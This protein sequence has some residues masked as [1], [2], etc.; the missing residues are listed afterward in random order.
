MTFF[1]HERWKLFFQSSQSSLILLQFSSWLEEWL[2][3]QRKSCVVR[4]SWPPLPFFLLLIISFLKQNSIFPLMMTVKLEK[5]SWHWI[6]SKLSYVSNWHHH[7]PCC[8]NLPLNSSMSET[9]LHHK[10]NLM[11]KMDG[12]KSSHF[13][14][15]QAVYNYLCNNMQLKPPHIVYKLLKM[16]HLIFL[17]WH[18]PPI[19]VLLKLTCLITLFDRKLQVFKNS[20]KWTIFGIFN[21]LLSTQNKT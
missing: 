6:A 3:K 10:S 8:S 4:K 16:S 11:K 15:Y 13:N 20:P 17:F 7:K 21:E 5:E 1:S 19:F 12:A 18:F 9:F 2:K 14:G